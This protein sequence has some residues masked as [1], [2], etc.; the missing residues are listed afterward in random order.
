MR[1]RYNSMPTALNKILINSPSKVRELIDQKN[2]GKTPVGAPIFPGSNGGLNIEEVRDFIINQKR[3]SGFSFQ[4]SATGE[5]KIQ[6]ELPGDARLMLGFAFEVPEA[7][8][9]FDLTINNNKLIDN[10]SELMHSSQ[11]LFGS[12]N[13]QNYIPYKQPLSSKQNI[14]FV[15]RT[16]VSILQNLTV[17]YI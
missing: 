13:S 4:T 9:T 7:N 5:V 11:M 17:Y 15:Y 1:T 3:A 6:V 16:T 10:A 12:G 8:A 2:Q 14:N